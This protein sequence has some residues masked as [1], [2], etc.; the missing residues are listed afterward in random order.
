MALYRNTAVD[1][2]GDSVNEVTA[3]DARLY[4]ISALNTSG[5]VAYIHVYA[6]AATDVTPGTTTPDATFALAATSGVEQF[7]VDEHSAS[8]WT[9][10]ASDAAAGS[11]TAPTTVV[12]TAKYG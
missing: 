9:I 8:G 6:L 12:L 10:C 2:D 1:N 11:G 5:A 3:S 4:W 7:M